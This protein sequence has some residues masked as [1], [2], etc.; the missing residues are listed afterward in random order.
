MYDIE[1]KPYLFIHKKYKNG[2]SPIM[3]R[4]T[5]DRKST[6][7]KTGYEATEREWDSNNRVLFESKLKAQ[8][9]GFLVSIHSQA[10]KANQEIAKMVV[11]LGKIINKE[12]AL[13]RACHPTKIKELFLGRYKPTGSDGMFT[14]YMNSQVEASLNAGKIRT[15]QRYKTVL[16][17]FRMFLG[18]EGSDLHFSNL[19]KELL[20]RFQTHLRSEGN[21]S[22]TINSNLRAIR[23]ILYSAIEDGLFKQSDNPFFKFKWEKP[24]EVIKEKLTEA[25]I[26]LIQEI[27]LPRGGYKD[28]ARDTFVFSFY[29]SG[30]R[31]GDLLQLRLNNIS[32]DWQN[33]TTESRITYVTGKQ[34]KVASVK[35][36]PQLIKIIKKYISDTSNGTDY[37]FP[38]LEIKEGKK[39]QELFY[40]HIKAKTAL[41]NKGLSAIQKELGIKKKIRNHI[42]RHS[43]A[44]FARRKN[45]PLYDISKALAHS[46]VGVTEAYLK[47]LDLES[48]DKALDR[49]FK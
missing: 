18:G 21:N 10:K 31:I 25:E 11:E 39:N 20:A 43:F 38:I 29:A 3:L 8:Q 16:H 5:K 32:P 26:K 19:N 12:V 14:E 47:S 33:L 48:T 28:I 6:Y 45:M 15:S 49:I 2:K 46:K 30:I 42:S 24:T 13:E 40:N 1:I 34:K 9:Q 4:L 27:K 22:N 23:T 36:R 44:D 35:V 7:I 41:V 37:I 17:K